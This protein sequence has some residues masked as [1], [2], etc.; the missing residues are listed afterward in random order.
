MITV[1]G[2]LMSVLAFGLLLA[3][4]Q[5]HLPHGM[6]TAIICVTFLL[7]SLWV[8]VYGLEHETP[9]GLYYQQAHSVEQVDKK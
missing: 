3:Y 6:P 1:L 8:L 2:L 4:L 5:S 7:V 9:G